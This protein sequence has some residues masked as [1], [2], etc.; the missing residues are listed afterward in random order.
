MTVPAIASALDDQ[1]LCNL[2]I[3]GTTDEL[4]FGPLHDARSIPLR[5]P[6]LVLR[7][8]KY[9]VDD[10]QGLCDPITVPAPCSTFGPTPALLH[11]ASR[12]LRVITTL[13]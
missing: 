6:S 7:L 8:Q 4:S 3:R 10:F 2:S 9:L 12:K 13:V 11:N 5:P 1:S